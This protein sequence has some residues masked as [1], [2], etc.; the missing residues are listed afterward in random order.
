M[1]TNF[2]NIGSLST[3]HGL[4]IAEPK[5]VFQW[6]VDQ[7]LIASGY[8]CPKCKRQMVLRPRRDI[9]DGFNWVC[10]VRGQNAH[11]VK[12][13]VRGGSWFERSNLPIPTILQ[14]VIYW[15]V[16]MKS[17]FIC[18]E[19]NIGT[20]TATDWA[21]FCREVC[22]DIL[23]WRSGK[24][25]GPGIVVE[26]DE[27]KFGKR[28]YNRGKRVVGRWVFGGVER[29][30]NNCFFAVVENRTRE[31]LLSVIKEHILPGTTVMSDCWSSYEC[32]SDEGFVHLA[33]NHSLH[34]VDPDTGAHT[35]SI[36]GTWSAI[37]R[38]LQ[39]TNHVKGQFDSYMATY[40][41]KRKHSTAQSRM[42]SLLAMIKEVYPPRSKDKRKSRGKN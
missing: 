32:L 17:K 34:F 30:S 2:G 42:A 40:M 8:E 21:S 24:I 9:S 31:V 13:S 10:R 15:C 35:N 25:G 39:G 26:I 6:C 23:I 11:H 7:G 16:E 14:F 19:L 41:C 22:Q 1:A 27:S 38:N 18:E 36:E 5:V 4:Q 20:A 29:G 37:K 3:Y 12:R 28:K 33:V